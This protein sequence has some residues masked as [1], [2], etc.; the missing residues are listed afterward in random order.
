MALSIHSELR[1][2]DENVSMRL[3]KSRC[4]GLS[5]EPIISTF[6]DRTGMLWQGKVPASAGL[7]IGYMS[8]WLIPSD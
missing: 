1:A 7:R 8:N 5:I 4:R 3:G 6:S 2:G